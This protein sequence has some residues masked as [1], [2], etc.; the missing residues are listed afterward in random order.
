MDAYKPSNWA[1]QAMAE[2]RLHPCKGL[3]T[4]V[5]KAMAA[6][7][8]VAIDLGDIEPD[9]F[10]VNCQNVRMAVHE[11]DEAYL[12]FLKGDVRHAWLMVIASNG[13]DWLCDYTYKDWLDEIVR[14]STGN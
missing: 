10:E 12:W 7:Y 4:I 2:N 8:T 11:V 1:E 6:G 14:D 9:L 13:E 5:R 3:A